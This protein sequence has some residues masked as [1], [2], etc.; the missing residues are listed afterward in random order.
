MIYYN[1]SSRVYIHYGYKCQCAGHRERKGEG[2]REVGKDEW[3]NV[4]IIMGYKVN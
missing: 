3:I 2:G 4:V 1:P